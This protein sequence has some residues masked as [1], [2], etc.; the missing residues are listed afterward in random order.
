MEYRNIKVH[1]S[2]E[3][4]WQWISVVS[5]HDWSPPHDATYWYLPRL[6]TSP[7]H[8]ATY[9]Y[10]PKL[11]T[12]TGYIILFHI[13]QIRPPISTFYTFHIIEEFIEINT[14]CSGFKP[15]TLWLLLPLQKSNTVT[16]NLHEYS[17]STQDSDQHW[18]LCLKHQPAVW[19]F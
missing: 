9:W 4:L 14:N 6:I 13:H 19:T 17:F 1:K 16:S 12:S 5:C 18:Q 11:I 15:T 3:E 10:L 7:P 8:D 2:S